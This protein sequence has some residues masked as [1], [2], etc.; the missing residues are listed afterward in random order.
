MLLLMVRE[1]ISLDKVYIETYGCE[2]NKSDSIDIIIS[3]EKKGYNTVDKP[4]DADVV[5]I[6]TCAVRQNA[7]ER[8]YGRIGYYKSLSRKIG[9]DQI[10]VVTGCMAQE[11][12]KKLIDKC[13]N[14][15]IVTGTYHI[16]DIPDLVIEHRK[17]GKKLVSTDKKFYDFSYFKKERA[18]SFSAWV[19]IIKG[20]SNFCS[21]CIV[22]YLRGPEKSKPHEEVID[23]VKKL[24]DNGVVEITLLGQNVNAYGKDNDDISFIELLERLNRI[25]GIKWIRFLTSHPKDFKADDIKRISTLDKVCKQFHLPLQSGS[26]RILSV[27]NRRYK[28]KDYLE[29]I[30][31]I[32]KYNKKYSI[33]TDIMVGF[34]GENEDDFKKTLDI[35]RDVEFD[36]AFMYRYSD[37][38]FTKASRMEN[39]IDI[40]VAK[41]RL[42]R[43]ID[44]QRGISKRKNKMEIGNKEEVLVYGKSKKNKNESMCKTET[45]K[46]VIVSTDK[47]EGD[48][49]KVIVT[50]ISGNTLRGR[51]IPVEVNLKT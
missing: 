43:L 34:P 11:W 12:G 27:M 37:R 2:M 28:V 25:D 38:P 33:T 8:I 41:E 13:E 23:E 29:I 3:F 46:I 14:V 50:E 51:E 35:V 42:I 21:Y 40:K 45:G 39:K 36:D 15:D 22:P 1:K 24:V 10:L 31:A 32:K 47:S 26:D 7:E 5:I 16:L 9:K 20:C 44:L 4:E 48:F 18:V 6:N 17:S 49:I 30:D 19:N